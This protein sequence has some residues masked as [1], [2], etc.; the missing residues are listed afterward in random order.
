[1]PKVKNESKA[2]AQRFSKPEHAPLNGAGPGVGPSVLQTIIANQIR[3]AKQ[4]KEN[5]K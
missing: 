1:M 3:K 4:R 2:D 5:G